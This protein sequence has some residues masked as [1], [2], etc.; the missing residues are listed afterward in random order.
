MSEIEFLAVGHICKD[1]TSSGYMLGGTVAYAAITARNLGL[2][3]GILTRAGDD[4]EL[5]P[6]LE[7]I[8][9]HKL[10]SAATTT[11][12]N[13]YRDGQR[14]QYLRALGDPIEARHVPAEWRDSPIV[15]L[16]PLA[17]ELDMALISMFPHSLI[18][19]SPQGWMRAWNGSGRVYS[20]PCLERL[21]PLAGARVVVL[22]EEDLAGDRSVL[23]S[24][25]SWVPIVVLTSGYQGAWLY[26][27]GH[28]HYIEPRATEEVDPTGAGD[29]FAAA[30]LIRLHET[31][32]PLEAAHFAS[33]A[34]SFSVEQPGPAG[35][36]S[37]QQVNDWIHHHA[38]HRR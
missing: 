31:D 29:V 33:V 22:S 4:I 30:F 27:E 37:R 21:A 36:P 6:W 13:I 24:L 17:Q 14:V 26:H 23:E 8:A 1:V 12:Q 25:I 15:L 16:G 35:I 2:R 10:P 34:A 38:P 32:N 7:G 3:A 28:V 18:G 20:R 11:F 9:I 19:V 5:T